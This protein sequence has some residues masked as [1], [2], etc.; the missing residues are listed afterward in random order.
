MGDVHYWRDRLARRACVLERAGSDETAESP[1]SWFGRVTVARVG[2]A[3]PIADGAPMWPLLQIVTGDLPHVPPVL[4]DLAVIQV[5]VNRKSLSINEWGADYYH[6]PGVNDP[7]WHLRAFRCGEDLVAIAEPDHDSNLR[8]YRGAWRLVDA[9][10]PTHDDVPAELP[11]DLNDAYYDLGFKNRDGTKV[12]G[13]PSNVQSEI[14]WAPGNR[15]P[16]NPEYVFQ[17]DSD[18]DHGWAWGDSG[19]G[20]VGRGTGQHR[21]Q[22]ALEWQCY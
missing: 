12:G 22:W 8:P 11:A 13:W 18:Y 21:D 2:D 6:A 5:F 4:A 19:V 15:H 9:D 3:W 7:R 20:Y 14:F 10:F 16:H 1:C 17:I